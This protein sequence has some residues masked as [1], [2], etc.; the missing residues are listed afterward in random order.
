[1]SIIFT[2]AFK[3]IKRS[4]WN[5]YKRTNQNYYDNFY[6]L[7]DTIQYKLIVYLEPDSKAQI[8]NNK[9]FN[10]NIIFIDMNDVDTFYR[11]Y[12]EKD[13]AIIESD[14]YKKKIPEHRKNNPEH[15][16][17][18]YT[19][20][21][22]SKINF[23]KHTQHLFP[24]YEY[25]SWIDFC[26]FN[27][28]INNIPKNIN[29]NL[30]VPKITYS[31]LN[32]LPTISIEPNYMLGSD[33]IYFDGSSFIVYNTYVTLLHDLWEKKII[34]YQDKMITDD[35]QNLVLQL[36]FDNPEIFNIIY[37]KEWFKLYK[38]LQ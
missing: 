3:D 33:T 22:N 36:Y 35:D 30:L 34:E 24:T 17:S 14:I 15:V 13:K 12:L 20:I 5:S 6:N 25:Y 29:I 11:K 9:V 10:D 26:T 31:C 1:M 38:H 21:T 28:N 37:N 23:I 4:T 7:V 19:M 32:I 18:E 8:I 27:S 16:F 2:T